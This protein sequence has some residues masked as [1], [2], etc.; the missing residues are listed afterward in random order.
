[1]VFCMSNQR[2]IR[3]SQI[4]YDLVPVKLMVP[5]SSKDRIVELVKQCRDNPELEPYFLRNVKTGRIVS[6]K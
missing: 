5:K 3:K 1:M 2:R 4:D 6:I